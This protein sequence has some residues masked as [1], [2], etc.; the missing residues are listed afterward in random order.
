MTTRRQFALGVLGLGALGGAAAAAARPQW[1]EVEQQ[2][3]SAPVTSPPPQDAK[4]FAAA[5]DW[6][7]LLIAAAESQIG[8]TIWYDGA[9]AKL[10]YPNGDV[11]IERGVCT[12]VVIRAYRDGLGIDLQKLVHEDMKSSFSAYP[13]TWGLAKPD[14]NID[15]RRVPN[16]RVYFERQN[17]AL[18]VSSSAEDYRP[19]DLVTMMLPGNLPHI[20]IVT[21]RAND[22]GSRPLCVHNIGAGTRLNDVLLAYE[23]NGHYRFKSS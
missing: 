6:A 8:K 15:H 13:K 3:I 23:M 19:G 20:A 17:A 9:Y 11:P 14:S 10:R 4:S 5:E 1:L 2:Y 18:K 7:K 16:L 12:D 22:D 21:H